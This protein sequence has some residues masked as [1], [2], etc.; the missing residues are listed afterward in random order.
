MKRREFMTLLGGAAAWPV[1]ARAQQSVPV[2]AYINPSTGDPAGH[3]ESGFRQGLKESGFIEGKNVS[4]E[5][6]FGN[7]QSD[8]LR[9]IID[10]LVR[11]N[12]A[13][14][15]STGGGTST[16]L[17][18]AATS[19]IPVVFEVGS[20]PVQSG[21]VASLSHPGGN[22]TGVNSSIGDIW[23]KLFDLIA[24]LLPSSRVFGILVSGRG[25]LEGIRQ[26]MQPAADSIGRKVLLATAYSSQELDDAF[27]ALARQGAEA[28]V[29][30]ASPLAY[31][32]ADQLIALAARYSLP[33]IY[34]FREIPAAGG[35]MSYGIK[36]EESFR[37]VGVYT[38][39][40]L[41]G[42]KPADLPV[43]LPTRF[44]FV[45]NLKTAKALGLTVRPSLLAIADEVIE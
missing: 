12:V 18:K 44:D 30:G 28:I 40:V 17:V 42:E 14:I 36:I 9:E 2:V 3:V 19:K 8:R 43:V 33:A 15:A 39:R 21:L 35:L 26:D 5:Y 38:G 24:K 10:D 37:L 7:N 25:Q 41:K 45:I 22:L 4:V 16:A 13:A 6:H 34:A 32:R 27:A 29:V 1:T 20:D 11:R 23:S 31:T